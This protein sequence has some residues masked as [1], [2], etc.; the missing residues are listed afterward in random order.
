MIMSSIIGGRNIYI[1]LKLYSVYTS[2]NLF[3]TIL[4]SCGFKVHFAS[5]PLFRT[6][7]VSELSNSFN[8]RR[9]FSS[10]EIANTISR[11]SDAV[12]VSSEGVHEELPG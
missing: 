10:A 6:E 3:N 12:S 5:D 7:T 4:T 2:E 8:R 9:S 1:Y 11:S